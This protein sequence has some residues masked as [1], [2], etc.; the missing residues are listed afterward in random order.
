MWTRQ[1][2]ETIVFKDKKI[3]RIFHEN[4]W[5]FSIIDI[6]SVLSESSNSRRYWSDLK[7][8]LAGKEGVSELYEKIVQLKLVSADGKKYTT[9]GANV[10]RS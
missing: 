3:R 6:V 5:R 1:N 2:T 4:E 10:N 8:Q 9:D 7:K